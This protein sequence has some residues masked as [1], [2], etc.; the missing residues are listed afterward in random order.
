MT[1]HM[2]PPVADQNKELVGLLVQLVEIPSLSGEEAACQD[3]IYNWFVTHGLS[4]QRQMTDDGLQN[5]VVELEGCGSGPTLFIGG[6]CDTVSATVG[7][8]QPPHKA[9]IDSDRL[10]GLGAMDMKAG[11][12]AAMMTTRQLAMQSDD[13]SGKLIFA[14]LADEEARS[15]GANSFIKTAGKIDAAIMCEPHFTKIGIGAIGKI[16]IKVEITGKSAHGSRPHTGVNAITEAAKLLVAIDQTE[17]FSHPQFG[18]ATHCVLNITSG[19]GPYEIRVPDHCVFS[20]NW[21]FMPEETPGMAIDLLRDLVKRLRLTAQISIELQDPSYESFL[22]E[23]DSPFVKLLGQCFEDVTG[24]TA[25]T[26]F[27]AGVSDAN[28]FAGRAG[29]PTVLF[30]PGGDGMHAPNE[31]A[32]LNQLAQ[33]QSIYTKFARRFL[34]HNQQ[35]RP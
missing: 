22:L 35:E 1:V 14:A 19:D 11:L 21:H 5:V 27:C 18:T 34:S 7:W 13:W 25:E 33:A 24:E 10:Y 28:I 26:E 8:T 3:F 9:F 23:T 32:D 31:W 30:G 2:S 12:A 15:R 17:R 4:P 16:N 20:I 29:I 6:H